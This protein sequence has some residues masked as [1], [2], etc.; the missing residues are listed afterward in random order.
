MTAG[1]SKSE[2]VRNENNNP[3]GALPGDNDDSEGFLI[4]ITT[5]NIPF[6]LAPVFAR[7]FRKRKRHNNNLNSEAC[8][9]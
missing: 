9:N 5:D 3:A 1:D 7:W 6:D 8:D 4:K 2:P